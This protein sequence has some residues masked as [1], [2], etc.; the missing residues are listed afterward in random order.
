VGFG[1]IVPTAPLRL[2]AGMKALTSFAL[3]T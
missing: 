2:L 1:D 3:I